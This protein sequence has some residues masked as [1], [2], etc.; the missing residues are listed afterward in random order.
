MIRAKGKKSNTFGLGATVTLETTEGR[1]VREINN[2][3]SYV[4]S[5]D[6]RLHVGLGAA[7]VIRQSEILWPSGTRQDLKDV[8][9]NQVLVIEE[10]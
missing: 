3:A 5:N 2:T 8:A 4:S 6:I 9:V 1:Q 10:P 7:K